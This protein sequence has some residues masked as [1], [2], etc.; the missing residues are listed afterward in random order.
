MPH[1]RA[2]R[3]HGGALAR[4]RHATNQ[5]RRYTNKIGDG[6][7]AFGA[8]LGRNKTL[9]RLDLRWNKA[10]DKV[11]ADVTAQARAAGTVEVSFV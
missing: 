5:S 2:C 11:V 8:A 1:A 4:A 10:S 6:A 7:A 9:V 3:A